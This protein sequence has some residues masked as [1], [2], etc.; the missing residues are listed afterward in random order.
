MAQ[1]RTEHDEYNARV[2]A[3]V[4]AGA[5]ES[6][7]RVVTAVRRLSRRMDQWFDTQ[8]AELDVSTAEWTVLSTLARASGGAMTPSQ[9]ADAAAVAP[10]S[11]TGRL[12]R[13][14]ER[15][16]VTRESDPD[17]RTRVL[18]RLSPAGWDLHA[19][20]IRE[21]GVVEAGVLS[22]LSQDQQIRLADF[23]ET[24]I[25]HVDEALD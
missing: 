23:L 1:M 10:S 14:V 5:D 3:Y 19:K 8:L 7:Q 22:P 20:A 15:E 13:M 16:L 11:M 9:L 6:V 21:A 25:N 24:M 12:D 17:N 2:S 4:A 18:V